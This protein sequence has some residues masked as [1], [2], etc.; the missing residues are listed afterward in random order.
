[1][2]G[3]KNKS[4]LGLDV[5]LA[6]E[7]GV[8]YAISHHD[9]SGSIPY[10]KKVE[11]LKN[12]GKGCDDIRDLMLE[13]HRRGGS[14][15]RA[16]TLECDLIYPLAQDAPKIAG[17][18]KTTDTKGK[19]MKQTVNKLLNT[20]KTAVVDTA[21]LA[22]G[23]LVVDAAAAK[24][25]KEVSLLGPLAVAELIQLIPINNEHSDRFKH[26]ALTYAM[27]VTY[28]KTDVAKFIEELSGM[29]EEVD[30]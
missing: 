26:A 7:R 18:T 11:F 20:N 21:F 27:Y 17:T 19:S 5:A 24:L 30:L 9:A 15:L 22:L 29:A 13:Y 6:A 28:Q 3:L 10:S 2:A 1:M 12:Q 16:Q 4:R 25:P 8:E 14:K 23:K